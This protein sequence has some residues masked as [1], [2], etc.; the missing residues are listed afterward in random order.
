M[1]V[2]AVDTIYQV[3]PNKMTVTTYKTLLDEEINKT[4][5]KISSYEVDLYNNRG[6]IVKVQS[7]SPTIDIYA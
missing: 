4:Y 7:S 6:E 3:L 5:T 1:I 2:S